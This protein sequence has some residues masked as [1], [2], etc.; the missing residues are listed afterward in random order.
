MVRRAVL[1]TPENRIPAAHLLFSSFQRSAASGSQKDRAGNMA[2]NKSAKSSPEHTAHARARVRD[3]AQRS[4]ARSEGSA[5]ATFNEWQISAVLMSKGDPP[6]GVVDC[7]SNR[8]PLG[9]SA[10]VSWGPL[11]GVEFRKTDGNVSTKAS[12]PAHNRCIVA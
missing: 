9:F 10:A 11:F 2:V 6:P 7:S 1:G 12:A 8:R 5:V 4:I 3:I